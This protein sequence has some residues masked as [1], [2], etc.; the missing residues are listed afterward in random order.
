MYVR[1]C[2]LLAALVRLTIFVSHLQFNLLRY[3]HTTPH[4][5]QKKEMEYAERL[6]NNDLL[7]SW[8]SWMI[9][10]NLFLPLHSRLCENRMITCMQ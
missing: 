9:L 2:L 5:M 6:R 3:N 8:T 4:I 7:F 1:R 10:I